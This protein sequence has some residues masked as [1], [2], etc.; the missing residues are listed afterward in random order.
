[1]E[2]EDAALK[3]RLYNSKRRK[4]AALGGKDDRDANRAI[5]AAL[6]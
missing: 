4:E 1:V 6:R 5:G 3:G 2:V